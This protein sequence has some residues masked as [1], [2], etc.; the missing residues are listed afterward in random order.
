MVLM[1]TDYVNESYENGFNEHDRLV[2]L[3][4]A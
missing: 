3:L 4:G 1:N 2:S